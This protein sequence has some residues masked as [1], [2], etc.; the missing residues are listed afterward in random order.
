M[1]EANRVGPQ[2]HTLL[3]Y[4]GGQKK[5]SASVEHLVPLWPVNSLNIKKKRCKILA[6]YCWMLEEYRLEIL[7]ANLLKTLVVN[8]RKEDSPAAW[9][10]ENWTAVTRAHTWI[11]GAEQPGGCVCLCPSETAANL[12]SSGEF[13]QTAFF[14]KGTRCRRKKEQEFIRNPRFPFCM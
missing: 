7:P 2:M 8:R 6:L 4:W 10:T 14:P 9:N 3:L 5:C 1:A 13:L 12:T 11:T